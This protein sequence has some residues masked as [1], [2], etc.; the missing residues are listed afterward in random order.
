MGPTGSGKGTLLSNLKENHPEFIFPVSCTTRPVKRAGE[1]EGDTY[2]FITTEEFQARIDRGD[3]LEWASY[4]GNLYGTPRSEIIEPLKA[5]KI[6]VREVEVQGVRKIRATL[7]RENLFIIFVDAGSW[8]ELEIR[9][10]KRAPITE[11]EIEK[12]RKRYDDETSFKGEADFVIKNKD[13]IRK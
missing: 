2:Y 13:I 9:V 4:G 10:R 11:E 7:P 8:E 6:L 12:R 1:K 5:G 3:F